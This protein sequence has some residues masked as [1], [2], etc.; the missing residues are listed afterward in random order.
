MEPFFLMK[1]IVDFGSRR[2]RSELDNTDFKN[3][4]VGRN[5]NDVTGTKLKM[6][7]KLIY[8]RLRDLRFIAI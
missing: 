5:E 4:T 6:Q 1:I 7:N 8:S 3:D 2:F